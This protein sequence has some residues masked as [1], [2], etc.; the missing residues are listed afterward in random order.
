MIDTRKLDDYATVLFEEIIRRHPEWLEQAA[1]GNPDSET[2]FTISIHFKDKDKSPIKIFVGDGPE[3]L[4]IEWGE[5]LLEYEQ[6]L[7]LQ[8]P[9]NFYPNIDEVAD[10][11]DNTVNKF[12]RNVP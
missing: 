8:E 10:A 2:G 4:V 6:I 11:I 3:S 7:E 5:L 1:N 12:L 9:A